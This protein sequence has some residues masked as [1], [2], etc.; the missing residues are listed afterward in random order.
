MGVGGNQV[1]EGARPIFRD[2][3]PVLPTVAGVTYCSRSGVRRFL[4]DAFD[5]QAVVICDF[6]GHGGVVMCDQL[7]AGREEPGIDELSETLIPA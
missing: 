6:R 4:P 2:H 7:I 1:A 5:D 3:A